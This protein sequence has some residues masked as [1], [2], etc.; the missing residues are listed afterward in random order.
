MVSADAGRAVS[1]GVA[2][3]LGAVVATGLPPRSR[4]V[5][6]STSKTAVSTPIARCR[7][8]GTGS[9]L[10]DDRGI[11]SHKPG[12]A[13]DITLSAL[14]YHAAPARGR[15]AEGKDLDGR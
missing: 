7:A 11:D 6:S 13:P 8:T 12:H 15:T 10:A 4:N 9:M 1:A 5:V 3:A 14:Y 2:A